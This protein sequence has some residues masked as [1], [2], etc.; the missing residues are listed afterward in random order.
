[1]DITTSTTVRDIAV[2]FPEAT[3]VFENLRI[4]YCCGGSKPLGEACEVAGV[5]L[6]TV[7][8]MLEN[9][10]PHIANNFEPQALSLLNLIIHILDKHHVYTKQELARL[11]PL[12]ERVVAAHG[13]NHPELFKLVSVFH[14]LRDDLRPHMF[15][16]EQILFPYIVA[17]EKS[18]REKTL[19]PIPPF[20]TAANPIRMMTAE[21]DEAGKLLQE[22][23]SLANEYTVPAD[24]CLSYQTLYEALEAFEEDLHQHIHL[25]NNVLFPRA[26][27]MEDRGF[28]PQ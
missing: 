23:R 7:V 27:E 28:I 25:E 24:A 19:R 20:Q 9:A 6:E 14:R 11:E 26:I 21:H 17:L 8:Q 10:K 16:E 2:Q 4:D 3:R 22:M 18:L 13:R 5:S 12:F 15:K 1:L